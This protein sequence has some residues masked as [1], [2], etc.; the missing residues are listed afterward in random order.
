MRSI[1][2]CKKLWAEIKIFSINWT[3]KNPRLTFLPHIIKSTNNK[4]MQEGSLLFLPLGKM[5]YQTNKRIILVVRVRCFELIQYA[6]SWPYKTASKQ[7]K[8]Q[9][10]E[11]WAK[12]Q[13][14]KTHHPHCT[15]RILH[16]VG[17]SRLISTPF[18]VHKTSVLYQFGLDKPV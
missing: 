4:L 1:S 15:P 2:Q 14:W 3:I 13:C 16:M 6:K 5:L 18:K 11:Q 9:S 12:C 10:E 17:E 8:D 7:F